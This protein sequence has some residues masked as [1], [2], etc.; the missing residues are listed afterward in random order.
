MNI[1]VEGHKLEQEY[2]RITGLLASPDIIKD[3]LRLKEN[4]RILKELE[5]KIRIFR[6]FRKT[7][8]EIENL[9]K[10]LTKEKDS[11]MA[12]L[13]NEELKGLEE[14]RV[15]LEKE[16]QRL[17]SPVSK[18]EQGNV[19]M[20]IRA[21]TG[22]DEAALFARDLFKMYS[23]FAERKGW[24]IEVM[25]SSLSDRG[26]FKEVIYEVEG[27]G[28]WSQLKYESG[29]HRVQRVPETETMGRVHTSTAT[30]AVLP[31]VGEVD[32]KI[33]PADLEIDTFRAS[34]PGGQHVNK[35]SSAIRIFHKPS[36][37]T[38]QCQ[39]EKSQ[40]Q[41]KEKALRVLKAKL[42]KFYKDKQTE[43]ISEQRKNQIKGGE[44]SDKIRTYNFPQGRITDHRINTTIHRLKDVLDGK[45]EILTQVLKENLEEK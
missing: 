5:P 45:L 4:S 6:E 31:E 29:V 37:L 30:V 35:T 28:V 8:S 22:G 21:G 24:K 2:L 3:P 12:G 20:E 26:G 7:I 9:K 23:K 15:S 14:K 41:N 16:W 36:G 42:M 25:D 43:E 40:H 19:I 10:W 32:I 33:N 18:E 1:N 17:L 34:G 13:V 39:D 11:D 27:E 44:R 38:V